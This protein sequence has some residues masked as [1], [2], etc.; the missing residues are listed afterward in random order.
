MVVA[1]EGARDR[2]EDLFGSEMALEFSF[3]CTESGRQKGIKS[4][5]DILEFCKLMVK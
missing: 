3:W 1:R 2:I 5:S 4:C